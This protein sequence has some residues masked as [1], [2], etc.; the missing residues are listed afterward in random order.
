[1]IIQF[2]LKREIRLLCWTDRNWPARFVRCYRWGSSRTS[3][4]PDPSPDRRSAPGHYPRFSS[5]PVP[6]STEF[7]WELNS[8]IHAFL[9]IVSYLWLIALLAC[10][11]PVLFH[12]VVSSSNFTV[13]KSVLM[14]LGADKLIARL[15]FR[16]VLKRKA[17]FLDEYIL[18]FSKYLNRNR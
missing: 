9:D 16:L 8:I 4:P 11:V 14:A 2:N 13:V 3:R 7:A 17:F 5:Y 10:E 15:L 18:D 1:M 6:W 12:S